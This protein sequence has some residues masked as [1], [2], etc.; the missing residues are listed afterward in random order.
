MLTYTRRTR[1][2]WLALQVIPAEQAV[3]QHQYESDDKW[4]PHPPVIEELKAK[5]K[6]E[7]L[8]NMFM[9]RHCDPKGK[10]VAMCCPPPRPPL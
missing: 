2:A 6:A 7:G 8:F 3:L 4:G 9:N 5:A 1:V 10:C